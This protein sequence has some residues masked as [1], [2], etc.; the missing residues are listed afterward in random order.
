MQI[1]FYKYQGTGNDFVMIDNRT[2][3]FPK[4]NTKLIAHLC[5]RRFGVGGDG[6]ILLENDSETDFK[7][8]YYNSDGNQSSMCG[9][10]GRCLVA[11]AKKLQVID[12]TTTFIATDGLHH[13]TVAENGLVSLQMIDVTTIAITPDYAFLNTGSPHHVQIVAAL[14]HYNVKENGA[15][16]RYGE[17]YGK[18]GSNINFVHKIDETTF[19]LRTYE[20]GVEDETL[21]CGT[22]ATAVAIA[23]HATGQTTATTLDLTVEG[24]ELV[25]SFDEN[26]GK[27]TNIFLKGPA[28]FVFKGSVGV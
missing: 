13:A 4:E 24:G 15:A 19:S 21:A 20:R 2:T 17:L 16:I 26:Q 25:V 5:D 27:Y 9:N 22:G 10:G 1:E 3:F 12:N 6:L 23:M 14:A 18:E 8:V 28:E 11:F 7:M